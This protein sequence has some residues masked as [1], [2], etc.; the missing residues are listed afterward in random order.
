MNGQLSLFDVL[1]G[2]MIVRPCD[3]FGPVVQGEADETMILPHPRLAW[4]RARIE[5]HQHT[6][7]L[8][9][10]SVSLSGDNGCGGGY[11]VG[12]KWGRFAAS[13][14]DALHYAVQEARDKIGGRPG[15]A[16]HLKWLDGLQ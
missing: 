1:R 8:W 7:G 6:D 9:M 10:W 13:R 5:L 12:P 14:D 15:F 4:D 3:G 2:P 16:D 11:K